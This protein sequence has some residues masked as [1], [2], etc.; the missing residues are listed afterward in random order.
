MR[1]VNFVYQYEAWGGIKVKRGSLDY[2]QLVQ[3]DIGLQWESGPGEITVIPYAAILEI[4][5]KE[6]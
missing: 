3:N 4:K 6:V 2:D 5:I 1:Q